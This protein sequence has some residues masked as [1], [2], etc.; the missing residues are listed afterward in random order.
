MSTVVGKWKM[1][2]ADG[3]MPGD[4][5]VLFNAGAGNAH[6]ELTFCAEGG[7]PLGPF[8]VVVPPRRARFATLEELAGSG[9]PGRRVPYGVV[10][11]SDVPVLVQHPADQDAPQAR[12]S[13]A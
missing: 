7:R 6:V 4:R 2:I 10:V 13:A 3:C 9:L 8:R 12:R 5:L 1:A 11:L